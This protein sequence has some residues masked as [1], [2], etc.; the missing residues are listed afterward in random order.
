[1]GYT[2]YA[3]RRKRL[4][5]AIFQRAADGCRKVVDVLCQEKGIRIQSDGDDPEP[6]HFGTDRVQFNGVGG[7]AHETFVVERNYTPYPGQTPPGRG[8][9]WFEFTKTARK[10]YDCVVCAC[11]V[12]FHHHFGMAYAVRSDG[13]DGDE[14]WVTARAFC[15]SALGYGADFTL[16]VAPRMTLKG[17]AFAGGWAASGEADGRVR[18]LSN[19][20][21]L[22]KTRGTSLRYELYDPGTT[23]GG[24]FVACCDVLGPL[25]WH[26]TVLHFQREF[27]AAPFLDEFAGAM[28]ELRGE[29]TPFLAWS[30]KLQDHGYDELARKVRE[31]IPR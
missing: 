17:L 7:E 4:P 14:G 26:A 31:H 5:R 28:R 8:E 16:N 30:D 12:V 9:G 29:W 11:L 6:P 13:D 24:G 15:Q 23:E 3:S 18:V 25:V 2:H 22:R 19:G 21:E 1:M 20:W 10:P 27:A